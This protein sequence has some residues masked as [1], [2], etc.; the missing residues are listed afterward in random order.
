MSVTDY[1]NQT[2]SL[3]RQ[4]GK[5]LAG[6]TY[7]A[8]VTLP[9]RHQA[10]NKLVITPLGRSVTATGLVFLDP[11]TISPGDRLTYQ[12]IRS[13]VLSVGHGQGLESLDHLEIYIG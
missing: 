1:A 11:T 2:I 9:A 12:G 10:I 5:T 8:P 7:A 3:E 6:Q 4:S 13:E